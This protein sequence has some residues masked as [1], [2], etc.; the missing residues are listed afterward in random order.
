MRALLIDGG[1]TLFGEV[2]SASPEDV[3][4]R[5]RALGGPLPE[6]TAGERR[7]VIEGMEAISGPAIEQGRQ[8]ADAELAQVL[9]GVRAGL[10]VRTPE[11]RLALA[12]AAAGRPFPGAARLLTAAHQLGLVTVLV[13]NTSWFTEADYR[14]RLLDIGLSDGIEHVVSSFDVGVRKPDRR[15]FDA[16]LERARSQPGECVMAGDDEANDIVPARAMGMRTVRVTVQ[17]PLGAGTVADAVA[18]TLDE[19]QHILAGW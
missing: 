10:A 19:L 18:A 1:A 2:P 16:A 4:L 13:S 7:R 5:A 6:L 15:M 14:R 9:E 17:H 8:T 12:G 11:V 3:E